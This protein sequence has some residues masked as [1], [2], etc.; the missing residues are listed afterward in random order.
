TEAA[1]VPQIVVSTLSDPKT[2]NYPLSQESPSVFTYIYEGLITENGNGE[3]EP[4]LAESWKI[5]DDKRQI[6]FTLRDGLKWSDG[7]PL[8]ADDITFTYNDLYFNEKI[9]TDARDI[10][11]IGTTGALPTVSK[12]DDRHVKFTVP[13]PFAPFLRITGLPIL[14]RHTLIDS[15]KQT[16]SDGNP[17]FLS[18]WGVDTDPRKIIANGPY[19]LAG[20]TPSQRVIFQRNP[21]YWRKDAQGNAL[22]YI[23]RFIWQIVESTDTSLLQFRSGGLDALGISPENFS[24]LKGEEKRGKFTIYNGGPAAGTNFISFNLNKARR[25]DG[26]PIV[27]P[28]KSKW[29]N[30]LAFRQAVAYAL[31]RQTMINN[32]FRGLGSAQDSPISL[33][34]PYYLSAEEGLKVYKY[35]PEKAKQLLREAGFKYNSQGQLQDAEGHLVRFT[36]ITN[37]GNKIREAMGAQVKQDLQQIGIQ[38]DFNPI[39]FNTLVEKLSTTRDWDCYLLGLTGGVEPNDGA[40]VWLSR[41][42]LH[43]FN[44][45]P[46]PGQPAIQGWEPTEWEKELDRLYI[47]GAQELDETKR[48]A[49]YA[50]TQQITQEQVPVIYL[51]NPLSL[52]AVR[53]RIQGVKFTALGGSLWNIYE[54]KLTE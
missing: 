22:P 2:F 53:D 44:Q 37:S 33:Q 5:S 23:E 40:N 39:N 16:G 43:S 7:E 52:S 1:Q 47:Q 11:R 12:I 24:L 32:T 4:A 21:Y 34:S 46:L 27:D 54:L 18:T 29:F 30:T 14:P 51:V 35:D 10:L 20:Y 45:G 13:E 26:R 28:I 50:K 19:L 17:K 41:G 8:T 15:V 9:P 3:I 31:D 6:V 25:A 48:K 38:V 49:I 42:G 36:L